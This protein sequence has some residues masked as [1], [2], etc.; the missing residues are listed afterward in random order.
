MYN[1][2]QLN[3]FVLS[4][5]LGSFS[6]CARHI[7]KVQS[8]VS[9]G[10]ANLEVDLNVELFDRTTRKPVLTEA[11]RHLFHFAEAVLQQTKELECA[12]NAL[13]KREESQ[14]SIVVDEALQVDRL[15]HIAETFSDTFT[16]TSLH[17]LTASGID[18]RDRVLEGNACIG[19]MLCDFETIREADVC[20]I[21][22]LAFVPVVN[23]Q[24]PLADL[25]CVEPMDLIPYRQILARGLEDDQARYFP[26][27][28]P[29]VWRIT[30]QYS[31][32]KMIE[33]GLGWGYLPLHLV[34]DKIQAG[35]LLTL[36]V[37]FDHKD[38]SI[39][40]EVVTAKNVTLGPAGMWLKQ[41]L[42][43]LLDPII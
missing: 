41:A 3:M 35:T 22:N 30:N 24:H 36:P 11:G 32:I 25:S 1:L 21:G 26:V 38:W 7:G 17:I 20:Y 10:I 4:A 12:S 39:P 37:S 23:H 5:K 40:V 15:Y 14:L 9:Q 8:A 27:V 6:A 31:M 33:R 2:D 34:S 18:V 43:A 42:K 28:S 19:V 16:A 29:H 13:T